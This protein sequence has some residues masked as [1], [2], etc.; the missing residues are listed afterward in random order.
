VSAVYLNF[1]CKCCIFCYFV[2]LRKLKENTVQQE[3][4]IVDK[5]KEFVIDDIIVLDEEDDK[6]EVDEYPSLTK[7][8][9]NLLKHALVGRREEVSVVVGHPLQLESTF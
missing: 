9:H 4:F 2:S 5:F 3:K 8:H 7:D 1:E 6:E